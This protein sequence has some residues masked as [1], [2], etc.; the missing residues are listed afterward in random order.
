MRKTKLSENVANQIKLI[1][2]S[3]KLVEARYKFDIWEMRVFVKM[4]TLIRPEDQDFA[5]YRINSTE[6]IHDFGLYDNGS[7]YKSIKEGAEKLLTKQVEIERIDEEGRKKRIKANL[8]SSTE[9]F[10][11]ENEGTDIILKFDPELRRHLLDLKEKYLTYDVRNILKL[12]SVYS[13]RI[14]E[15]LKQYE[16]MIDES[17][18]G[19]AKRKFSID[20]LKK[21]LGIEE[22]EYQLYGHFKNKIILKAQ[23]DLESE[24]DIRFE[25]EEEK[26]SRKIVSII[27]LIYRNNKNSKKEPKSK[28]QITESVHPKFNKIYTKVKDFVSVE[29]VESWF[30]EIPYEQIEVGVGYALSQHKRGKVN[31]MVKYLQKMVRTEISPT[32]ERKSIPTTA[33]IIRFENEEAVEEIAK[34]K[35]ASDLV[36]NEIC[37]DLLATNKTLK[38]QIMINM[39]NGL[40]AKFYNQSLSFEQNLKDPMVG[41]A[42][43]GLIHQA[44]PEA[45]TEYDNMIKRL[46]QLEK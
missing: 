27:F 3:N 30:K 34:L 45:F 1:R 31:D 42:M 25:I 28:K 36:F 13:I 43:K 41:G 33:P 17:K 4:L 40:F 2:K 22:G 20:E 11:D 46:K 39:Q 26:S 35:S 24:T 5:Q 44:F 8:I 23:K 16:G 9:S 37:N 10:V 38:N 18:Q 32:I 15:L 12:T 7:I 19:Y 14:Y 21:V 6:I 29:I